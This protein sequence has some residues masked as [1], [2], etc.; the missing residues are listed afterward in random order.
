MKSPFKLT[1]PLHFE[2]RLDSRYIRF[3]HVALLERVSRRPGVV[4]SVD[5][6]PC[7]N[8]PGPTAAALL[9]LDRLL[10]GVA[11]VM[12]APAGPAAV[13]PYARQPGA[14]P[15]IVLDLCGDAASAPESRVWR[16]EFD[17]A[18]HR[19]AADDSALLQLLLTRQAP[20]A[21]IL[22]ADQVV[23]V[24]RLGA[25]YNGSHASAIEDFLS[26]TITLVEA[27]LT[28]TAR[29]ITAAPAAVVPHRAI[30]MPRAGQTAL[31]G[32]AGAA[33]RHAYR[34]VYASPHWRV[35]WRRLNGPDLLD[36][37]RH[38]DTGWQILPDDGHRFYADPFP[39][40]RGRELTVF[41]EE[42]PHRTG[43]GVISAVRFD[44]SGPVGRPEIVLELPYHLSYPFVFERDG[45]TWL[46]PESCAA[47]SVDL[48]R[49]TSF[50][51]GWVKQATLLSDIV[52]SDATLVEHEGRWW[53]FAT[54]RDGG[55]AFSDALH[56][57]WA[58]DF[59]GPW[60]PHPAN[61]VMIDIASARPAGRMVV[62][63]GALLRPVQ[64]CRHGYGRALAIARVTK[65]DEEG[66]EQTVETTLT[67]GPLWPGSRLHTLNS[68]G[69]FE[70]IDGSARNRRRL[71]GA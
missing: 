9:Q 60:T 58:P 23:A 2:L 57:W 51:G 38:P 14:T 36:L 43:K 22:E 4:A 18:D 32:V 19:V 42:F 54:V 34:L 41:V 45:E 11:R 27:A 20:V 61:P 66:F 3:W 25:E 1:L 24:A 50:P 29:A 7:A 40:E 53:M 71:W 30:T 5:L 35:G 10:H 59:R 69:G 49:A 68:A 48:F 70:F 52:A 13:S 8:H 26:R 37:R 6:A 67:S 63:G 31:R 39:I 15:D 56:L 46:I 64:D 16:L 65:L 55:G 21:R 17:G 47:G 44:A 12:T 28:G 62:R 33:I